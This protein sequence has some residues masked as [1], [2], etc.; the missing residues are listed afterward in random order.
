MQSQQMD[1]LISSQGN[2]S[3]QAADYLKFIFQII[4]CDQVNENESVRKLNYVGWADYY[5]Q[6]CHK[7]SK[8][9]YEIDIKVYSKLVELDIRLG[10]TASEQ[11]FACLNR[12]TRSDI[13]KVANL[14]RM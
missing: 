8:S 10:T 6:K 3:S 11:L 9:D 13:I 4:D 12:T 7:K 14:V 5:L 1:G 2:L